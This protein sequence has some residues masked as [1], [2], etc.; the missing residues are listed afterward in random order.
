MR[1]LEA[2]AELLQRAEH[3]RG[4]L[5]PAELLQA[6][7]PGEVVERRIQVAERAHHLAEAADDVAR[8]P[9]VAGGAQRVQQR[10]VLVVPGQHLVELVQEEDQRAAVA[11]RHPPEEVGEEDRELLG[12]QPRQLLRPQLAHDL[13]HEV[14]RRRDAR[15]NP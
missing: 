14:G 2:D 12:R 9:L 7:R 3:H 8:L 10:V 13:L 6:H 15:C 11:L 1:P 4:G 5:L